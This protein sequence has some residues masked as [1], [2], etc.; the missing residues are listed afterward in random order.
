MN[1]RLAQGGRIDRSQALGF[2]F[3]GRRYLGYAGDTLA[4]ALLA[5]GVSLT[6]RSFKYHRPRGIVGAGVEEPATLVELMGEDA[7]GN[8]PA[9][10][11]PLRDGLA[12]RSVNCWPSP[13]FDVGAVTQLIARFIPA[14]FYYKTFKWPNWH[15]FE[16]SIRRAAGLAGAP[17]EPPT[18]GHFES[19]NAHADVLIAGAGPAGVMAALV[20]GRAGA[21]VFLADDGTEAGGSLLSRNLEVGGKDAL[22]WV[23]EAVIELA[24]MP[25]VVH[26]QNSTVWAYRE[27]NL[28]CV[29]ERDPDHPTLLERNWRVRAK[30]VIVATGAIERAMVFA[31]NDR[32]GV[33]LASAVQTYVNRYA[34]LPGKRAV[35]FANNDSAY[36][37]A[38]DF[39]AAGG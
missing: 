23:A 26:L 28:V 8:R 9:T 37:A 3:N 24:A 29:N 16:P 22:S 19:R 11:V 36:A 4:S 1:N 2:S 18:E 17:A 27:H 35:F 5:N 7:S 39:A 21:R 13:R 34:V 33:M 10:T 31:N 32:P 15:L 12:A 38:A 25:N 20:A 14:G 6:A 30:Q